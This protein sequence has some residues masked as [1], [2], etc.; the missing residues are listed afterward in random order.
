MKKNTFLLS[1][2]LTHGYFIADD[3]KEQDI[4]RPYPPLGILYISAFLEEKGIENTVFDSTFS[5]VSD[6]K[7]YVLKYKPKHIAFYCN[8]MTKVQLLS[9]VDF[10]KNSPEL[11]Q[12][13]IIG[14]GPDVRYNAENYIK[15]GFDYLVIGEGEETTYDLINHLEE[16]PNA[17]P[18]DIN[19]LAFL[20]YEG[21]IINTPERQKIK[22]LE[23]LPLPNRK[24]IN[25]HKYL[26][27]WKKH[28]GESTLSI[29]TQRG[30]PF[31]CKW[32]STAVYGQSYR[33]RK[34]AQVVQEMLLLQKEYEPDMLWFVDDVFT[35]SH[36]WL[37]EFVQ[38][39]KLA[40]LKMPFECITRAD[41]MNEEVIHLLKQAG[42]SRVW[43]GAESGSQKIIDAM[44]RR[45]DVK[46]VRKMLQDTKKAG[47]QTGTF[48]MVG[49]PGE[50][51]DDI[52]ETITHLIESDPDIY[53]ITVAYPIKGTGLF[54]EVINKIENKPEWR[55]SSDRDIDFTRTY[56][57]VYYDYAV[58]K[59]YNEVAYHKALK[60][61]NYWRAAKAK[62]KSYIMNLAMNVA[63]R[64]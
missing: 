24:G 30:C 4:M 56:K 14:G 49:Y 36:K 51:D 12:T 34:P 44:D 5:T 1:L 59:I 63:K 40:N 48:I 33:R 21:T 16:N 61:N 18:N 39:L 42:C 22:E 37:R 54:E 62:S 15:E 28:H 41:R 60:A 10:V 55:T 8:L 23:E 35:V 6:W 31:T 29:S 26:D 3:L 19:G 53:T 45:V 38:E 58:R 52:E 64:T 43:I 50:T 25:M 7:A 9:L 27:V 47:I 17:L 11:A 32:C 46:M 13:T 57:R 20:S 2:L